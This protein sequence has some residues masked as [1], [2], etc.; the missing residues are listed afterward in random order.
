MNVQQT[1]GDKLLRGSTIVCPC[2]EISLADI[3]RLLSESPDLSFD[4]FLEATG[5]GSKCTACLLDV[6]Q[7][8]VEVPR[9]S[10]E[11]PAQKHNT[12]D[13]PK[14]DALP[15][16]Q[17]FYQSLDRLFPD[18]P[19][20]LS[21]HV[22][23]LA[24]PDIQQWFWMANH[25]LLY[26]G[27]ECAPDFDVDLTLRNADGT[28]VW[29]DVCA[30]PAGEVI[31][32]E[33]SDKLLASPS[34]KHETGSS[35]SIGWLR[36]RRRAKKSGIR[37]TTRSQLEIVSREGNCSVHGQRAGQIGGGRM[38]VLGR[39]GEDRFFVSIANVQRREL[40]VTFS[41]PIDVDDDEASSRASVVTVPPE[42]A[43]LH[44]IQLTPAEQEAFEGR[45]YSIRW[46]A[47]G[48]YKTHFIVA[49]PDLSRF[50]IDHA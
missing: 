48:Y 21:E 24:G 37:G 26:E 45:L 36:I 28:I 49:S 13:K 9:G 16:K 34:T 17:R 44:E 14:K 12:V 7:Y 6:E 22:P 11:G 25:S 19:I 47:K 18:R 50:S 8:F 39:A 27:K 42:G 46:S 31:R 32:E 3:E 43:A 10:K 1:G 30:L 38:T 35:L 41:Y 29:R 4:M 20:D 40:I 2:R 23:V 33:I 5:A 15:L